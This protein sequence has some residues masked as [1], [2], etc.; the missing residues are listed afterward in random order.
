[1]HAQAHAER[2]VNRD[3]SSYFGPVVAV[4]LFALVVLQTM[5]ALRDAG[6]WTPRKAAATAA[7]TDP[8]VA[9]D[10]VVN[11]P[12]PGDGPD[13]AAGVPRDPFGLGRPVAVVTGKTPAPHRPVTP[14]PPARPVLTAIVWDAD[15]RALVRWNDREWTVR[16]GGLFDDF[17][18]VS[19]SREQVVLKHGDEN[20]V[21]TRKPQ[22]E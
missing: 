4:A 9:L 6:V 16:A 3:I 17:Q 14:P 18:V 19:I 22:G 1:M 11:D 15:P 5:G 8:L 7:A 21:L 13:D 20:I 12:R 10:G 2:L